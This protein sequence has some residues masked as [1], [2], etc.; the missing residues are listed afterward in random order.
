MFQILG[1]QPKGGTRVDGSNLADV[2]LADL[3]IQE[4]DANG[5]IIRTLS[6]NEYSYL[7]N[8]EENSEQTETEFTLNDGQV[9]LNN[10]NYYIFYG[11][12]KTFQKGLKVVAEV[13]G[14]PGQPVNA[15]ISEWETKVT[16]DSVLVTSKDAVYD[17]DGK[18]TITVEFLKDVSA[19]FSIQTDHGVYQAISIVSATVTNLSLIHI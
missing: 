16:S 2:N 7:L 18:A 1:Y 4:I 13:S 3:T 17:A 12:W 14:T 8:T 15:R 19:D 5:N 6:E 11:Q 10:T 9:R